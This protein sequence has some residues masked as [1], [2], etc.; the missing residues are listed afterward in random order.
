LQEIDEN[1]SRFRMN[2]SGFQWMYIEIRR[3]TRITYIRTV[4]RQCELH[5]LRGAVK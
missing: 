1:V 3:K 5:V 2:E 4:S